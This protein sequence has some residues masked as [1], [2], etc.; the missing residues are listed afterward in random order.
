MSIL[1]R[2]PGRNS[3]LFRE[4]RGGGGGEEQ[5]RERRAELTLVKSDSV[6]THKGI[7]LGYFTLSHNHLGLSFLLYM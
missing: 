7:E 3:R 2:A 1:T 5:V 6:R 4:E